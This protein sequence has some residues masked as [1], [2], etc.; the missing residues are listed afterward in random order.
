MNR[1]HVE[2]DRIYKVWRNMYQANGEVITI[3]N[4]PG[5]LEGVLRND[6][7]E[8]DEVTERS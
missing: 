3:D 7:R 6:Y 8:V 4:I 5:P 2:S 1:F